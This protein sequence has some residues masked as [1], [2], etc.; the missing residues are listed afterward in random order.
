MSSIHTSFF[1]LVL[2]LSGENTDTKC[3]Y[4]D[5]NSAWQG[6]S[7]ASLQE[8]ASEAMM[9]KPEAS[10]GQNGARWLPPYPVMTDREIVPGLNE[11]ATAFD[12]CG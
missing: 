2:H 11:A 8:F 3:Q 7:I 1:H 5:S 4:L 9:S 6:S 12:V 10:Q